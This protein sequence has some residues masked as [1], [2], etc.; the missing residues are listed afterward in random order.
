M[1]EKMKYIVIILL[2]F[3]VNLHAQSIT[4]PSFEQ[5]IDTLG[6]EMPVGWLTSDFLFHGSAKKDTL[7]HTGKY[8]I[9]LEYD[10]I[11]F[12]STIV[13]VD[14]N[15]DFSFSGWANC[16]SA[17]GGAFLLVCQQGIGTRAGDTILIP[18]YFSMNYR[19]YTK[20][21]SVPESTT[22]IIVSCVTIPK[23]TVYIDDITLSPIGVEEKGNFTTSSPVLYPPQ[24]NPGREFTVNYSLPA[25]SYSSI[26]IYDI[27]GNKICT[28]VN[29]FEPA[30]KHS[31]T[32]NLRSDKNQKVST[33]IYFCELAVSGKRYTQRIILIK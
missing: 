19:Q 8:A 4:N 24:P 12:V 25:A 27:A 9:K 31:V 18:V 29:E 20:T 23:A 17:V 3:A 14:S 7:S 2:L 26:K 5:W 21:F 22:S 11:A 30:G 6:I 32:W 10:S 33:G 28:L 1:E 16:P 13:L 15:K